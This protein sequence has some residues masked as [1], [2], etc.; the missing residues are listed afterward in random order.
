MDRAARRRAERQL[1][2]TKPLTLLVWSNAPY[3]GTGYGT[4]T[5]QIVPR[6]KADGHH[7]AVSANYGLQG[8][9][10][11]WEGIPLYPM[12]LTGYGEDVVAANFADW[13]REH[14]DGVPHVLVNFDAWVLKSPHW[15]ELPTSIWTMVDHQPLPP[16]VYQ[17]LAKPNITPIA[18][19]KFGHDQI[20]RTGLEAIYIPMAID[21][22]TYKPRPTALDRTGRQ[23]MGFD[24]DAEDFFIVSMVNANKSAGPGSI[25]RKAWAEQLLAF[26]IFAKG[27]PDVRLYIHTEKQGAFGGLALEPLLKAVG[28]KPDQYRFANQ[29]AMHNGIYS[30]EA[31]AAIYTATDLLS[32]ATLGE[33]FGLTTLEAAAC[34]APVVVNNFTCQ[35]EMIS[36][37]GYLTEGQPYWDGSQLS[38]FSIPNVPSLVDA[39]EQAYAKGR[40]RSKKQREHAM[41]Y[42]ADLIW[43]TRWRPYIQMLTT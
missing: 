19:S 34:E 2:D 18:V 29:W 1:K 13:K 22:E 31:M 40:V 8:M 39:Y 9:R 3:T 35:P 28:L 38:W 10:T 33:G 27:K 17:V 16:A 25:H 6:F 41:L 43:E 15:D 37:D 14:P 21:T 4:Q 5:A 32:A 42:D 30:N 20:E 24:D 12:G 7:V 36:D 26:S 23:I 11:E